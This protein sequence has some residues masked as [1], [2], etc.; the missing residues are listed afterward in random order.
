VMDEE[1]RQRVD[2][3]WPKLGIE[4]GG[5]AVGRSGGQG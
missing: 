4:L 1:T 3:M 2:E 5:K